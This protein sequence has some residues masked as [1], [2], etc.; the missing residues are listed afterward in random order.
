MRCHTETPDR[1][2][3]AHQRDTNPGTDT[4]EALDQPLAGVAPGQQ[5]GREQQRR[6]HHQG[7]RLKRPESTKR[8]KHSKGDQHSDHQRQSDGVARQSRR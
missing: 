4:A 6:K 8:S 1:D 7:S 5:H 2:P 3:H